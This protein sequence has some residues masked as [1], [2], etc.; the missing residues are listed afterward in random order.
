MPKI[1]APIALA[2]WVAEMPTP[3]AAAWIRTRSP[4]LQAAHDHQGR[5]RGGVV[6]GKRGALLERQLLGQGKRLLR[7][8]RDQLRLAV[9]AG[10]RDHPVADLVRT[11]TPSPT[12]SISPAT[13]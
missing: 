2:I 6:D 3:P 11:S 9:E 13:S 12:D 4:S 7:G 5:V 8:H 1:S 10:A